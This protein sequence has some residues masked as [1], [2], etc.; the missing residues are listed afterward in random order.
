MA[1]NF[2]GLS[3]VSRSSA[4]GASPSA[5]SNTTGAYAPGEWDWLSGVGQALQSNEGGQIFNSI[6]SYQRAREVRKAQDEAN[7]ANEARYQEA[8]GL[9][10]QQGQLLQTQFGQIGQQLSKQRAGAL[11]AVG[12]QGAGAARDIRAAGTAQQG[13]ATIDAQRRG[14]G[15]TSVLQG[16]RRAIAGDTNANLAGLS[17]RMA[18]ARAG[19]EL[20]NSLANFMMQRAQGESGVLGDRIKL[21]ESKQDRFTSKELGAPYTSSGGGNQG[22]QNAQSILGTVAAIA[23]IVAAFI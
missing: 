17:E 22:S 7:R 3:G 18:S 10:A 9:N 16:M 21:I 20:D 1:Y 2:A 4:F 12:S 5:N 15:G 13:A 14:L 6:L 19:V 11:G 23:P 8:L